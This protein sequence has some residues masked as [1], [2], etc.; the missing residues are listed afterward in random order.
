MA[1]SSRTT[2]LRTFFLK[3]HHSIYLG[4]DP[5]RSSFSTQAALS[6]VPCLIDMVPE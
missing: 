1:G 3:D 5:F 4:L 6:E 2:T